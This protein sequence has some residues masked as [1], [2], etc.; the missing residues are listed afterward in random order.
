MDNSTSDAGNPPAS[1]TARFTTAVRRFFAS[2]G[3]RDAT[4]IVI[5]LV[6]PGVGAIL[7]AAELPLWPMVLLSMLL[8]ALFLAIERAVAAETAEKKVPWLWGS[9]VVALLLPTG[10]WSYHRW[11]DS[12]DRSVYPFYLEGNQARV[13]QSAGK[14]GGQA[15]WGGYPLAAGGSY[16][17]ECVG[18]DSKGA[19][20]LKAVAGNYWYPSAF[21]SPVGDFN[22]S[23]MPT[24]GY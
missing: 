1:L 4:A 16:D 5:G 17:F 15:Q 11:V 7:G 23:D 21:L 18:K 20:W 6:S 12:D 24:C 19:V 22:T 9:L 13:L 2:P 10:A 3:R 8:A 14:P